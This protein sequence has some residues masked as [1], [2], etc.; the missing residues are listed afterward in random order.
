VL[1]DYNS[2]VFST[3]VDKQAGKKFDI[4]YYMKYN[5]TIIEYK[6]KGWKKIDDK[7]N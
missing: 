4:Y 7:H 1:I 3:F 2:T 6:S 5:Y